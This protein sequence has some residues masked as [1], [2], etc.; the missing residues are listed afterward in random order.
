MKMST[1]KFFRVFCPQNRVLNHLRHGIRNYHLSGPKLLFS[2]EN[3]GL[4][5]FKDRQTVIKSQVGDLKEQFFERM[6]NY[7]DSSQ[8]NRVFTA[9]LKSVLHTTET[10]KD[11]DVAIKMCKRYHHQAEVLRF[12]NFSFGPVLMRLLHCLRRSDVAYNIFMDQDMDG[13]FSQMASELILVDM[14][15]EHQEYQKVIDVSEA[16]ISQQRGGRY[17]S[18][19]VLTVV[20]AACLK[21]N[22]PETF[23]YAC[24]KLKESTKRKN[25]L[26][27]RAV[28]YVLYQAI[29][30]EQWEMAYSLMLANLTQSRT[31]LVP[32]SLANMKA[33]ILARNG[34]MEEALS[35]V[36]S[37]M[38]ERPSRAR[39]YRD[40][41]KPARL[42][43]ETMDTLIACANE[44]G[45][46]DMKDNVEKLGSTIVEHNL[47][48]KD[49]LE[50][51]MF[52]VIARAPQKKI[53]NHRDSLLRE[54]DGYL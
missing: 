15:F 22:T 45:S 33:V 54:E 43:S 51:Y 31:G 4:D 28:A 13:F 48:H 52:S 16:I 5:R 9:D 25:F 40:D 32:T 12:A 46:S 30:Q 27:G 38:K 36:E 7:M 14:L 37:L 1:L 26:P 19:D 20:T 41:N 6:D 49:P 53:I 44:N 17:L 2:R 29:K 39:K 24:D 10:Q 8:D 21:L 42:F 50:K 18:S 3:L 35:H 11:M 47:L 23:Q 34:K